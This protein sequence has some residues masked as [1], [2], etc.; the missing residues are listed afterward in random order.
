VEDVC[1][2]VN[3]SG[4]VTP[5]LSDDDCVAFKRRL[6][7]LLSTDVFSIGAKALVLSREQ[8]RTFC[9]ARIITDI[10][11]VFG[12]DVTQQPK[13]AVLIHTFRI[14]YHEGNL[15]RDFYVLLDSEDI[16]ALRELLDRA[17]AKAKSLESVIKAA[18]VTSFTLSPGEV[19][20]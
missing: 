14:S 5:R 3:E 7:D 18:N 1:D 9:R 11:P 10:R 20:E 8:E 16:E 19:I 6:S 2:A 15:L 13:A 12:A 17:D 4:I